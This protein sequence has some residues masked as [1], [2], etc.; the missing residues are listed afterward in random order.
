M[1]AF[2]VSASTPSPSKSGD[3]YCFPLRKSGLKFA[4]ATDGTSEWVRPEDVER[5]TIKGGA[6]LGKETNPSDAE[7]GAYKTA[8]SQFEFRVQSLFEPNTANRPG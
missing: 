7:K 1:V 3:A 2:P 6:L 8:L 4:T 5:F